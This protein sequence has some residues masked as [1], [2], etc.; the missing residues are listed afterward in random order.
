[1]LRTTPR[2]RP[3]TLARAR[4]MR[5][6]ATEAESRLWYALREKL[7]GA[8]FRRQVPIGPYFADFASHRCRLVVEVDGS[9]H[10]EA[11]ERDGERT[12]FLQSQGYRV[13]RFWNNEVLEDLD[14]VLR[15]IA[16]AL[17]SPLVGE[18]GP[19]GR[20]RG[21]RRSRAP[22][23]RPAPLTPPSPTRG[24]GFRDKPTVWSF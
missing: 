4:A 14:G 3:A 16:A 13:L 10:A 19:K 6:D 18:G 7:P 21:A 1:M 11:K 5:R 23:S 20:M 9:Q 8:K 22:A 15:A 24:E 2:L 17:P 12:R